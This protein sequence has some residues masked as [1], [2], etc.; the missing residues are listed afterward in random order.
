MGLRFTTRAY[1]VLAVAWG[2][3]TVSI[4]TP[5]A[6]ARANA[7]RLRGQS[8]Q[9]LGLDGIRQDYEWTADDWATPPELV[10]H[11]E[12]EFGAFTLDPCAVADTAKAPNFYTPREDG[13]AMPWTGRV[14]CN[15]PYSAISQWLAKATTEALSG[16]CSLIVLLLPAHVDRAWWHDYIE[17][18]AHVKVR[19]IRGRV[20][21]LKAGGSPGSPT[22]G[23]ALVFMGAG[24]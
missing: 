6:Q 19:F 18:K 7:V 23:S 10:R 5:R 16:R 11:L 4:G 12:A 20:R 24:I 21:F 22:Y 17:A 2:L 1:L 9:Q 13:L 8:R 3:R 14:F 15:P